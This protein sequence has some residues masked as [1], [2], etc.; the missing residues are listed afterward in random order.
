MS[1]TSARPAQHAR[2]AATLFA[3]ARSALAQPLS[4]QS[5]EERPATLKR[6]IDERQHPKQRWG[7]FAFDA[8]FL[9]N[10]HFG[11][12]KSPDIAGSLRIKAP[13]VTSQPGIKLDQLDRN[14]VS[15]TSSGRLRT[16]AGFWNITAGISFWQASGQSRQRVPGRKTMGPNRRFAPSVEQALDD[17]RVGRRDARRTELCRRRVR[18]PHTF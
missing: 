6:V 3:L 14:D 5:I 17:Q 15:L 8:V 12:T 4:S 16:G 1:T 2:L 7:F 9:G 13:T 10:I 18:F 11:H